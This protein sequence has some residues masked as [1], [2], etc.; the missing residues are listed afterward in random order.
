[1]IHVDIFPLRHSISPQKNQYF[2]AL[3]I[4][5]AKKL[6]YLCVNYRFV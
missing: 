1:M 6:F 4:Y 2:Y 5:Y 3:Y